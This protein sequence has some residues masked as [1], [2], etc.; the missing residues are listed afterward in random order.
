MHSL[1][2]S[3]KSA[4]RSALRVRVGACALSMSALVH[5]QVHSLESVSALRVLGQT[6]VHPLEGVRV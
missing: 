3:I 2:H 5:S 1:V 4:G 6:Q